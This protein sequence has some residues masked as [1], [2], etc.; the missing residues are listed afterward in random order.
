L[1]SL[2][3]LSSVLEMSSSGCYSLQHQHQELF[4]IILDTDWPMLTVPSHHWSIFSG[5]TEHSVHVC[6]VSLTMIT[7]CCHII[8]F[9]DIGTGFWNSQQ[10]L[11]IY[12]IAQDYIHCS[13]H[14]VVLSHII[15]HRYVINKV[16]YFSKYSSS[17]PSS[18]GW[19]TL[20]AALTI[21]H[22][23][24]AQNFIFL[25]TICSIFDPLF[26]TVTRK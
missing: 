15:D 1:W 22:S 10:C 6:W 2:L 9:T 4:I 18:Y 20:T 25:S 23:L 7:H 24:G 14:T 3:K 13:Q 19:K 16:Q 26:L 11:V 17:V 8:T 5:V 21:F 12:Y